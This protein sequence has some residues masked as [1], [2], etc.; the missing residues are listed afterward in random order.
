MEYAYLNYRSRHET[1]E[2]NTSPIWEWVWEGESKYA[3]IRRRELD[4]ANIPTPKVGDVIR[5]GAY[6]VRI[7]ER[8]EMQNGFYCVRESWLG[9][10]RLYERKT[11]LF[12][13]DIGERILWT[14][15]IW[16]LVDERTPYRITWRDI[17]LVKWFMKLGDRV[18]SWRDTILAKWVKP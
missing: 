11:A 8:H 16:G 6:R 4:Y 17:K 15:V 3:H 5:L 9:I 13:K 2:G 7:I 18:L 1:P 14:M 10:P 12:L